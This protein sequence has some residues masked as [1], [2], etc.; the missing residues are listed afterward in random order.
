[1]INI[2]IRVSNPSGVSWSSRDFVSKV[3][4]PVTDWQFLSPNVLHGRDLLLVKLEIVCVSPLLSVVMQAYGASHAQDCTQ[5]S[6]YFRV[7]N[8]I[9]RF[10]PRVF[11]LLDTP[12]KVTV[13]EGR[14][15]SLFLNFLRSESCLPVECWIS[16]VLESWWCFR[17]LS[18]IFVYVIFEFM[19]YPFQG[20]I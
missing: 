9:L 17:I 18:F 20:R 8:V 12:A 15:L 1:M 5:I 14:R 4:G 10:N 16:C 7:F 19:I 6:F 11:H 3:Q 2:I 13:L